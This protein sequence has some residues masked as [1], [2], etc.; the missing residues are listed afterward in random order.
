MKRFTIARDKGRRAKGIRYGKQWVLNI[1][2][3]TVLNEHYAKWIVQ[4]L[5]GERV[6]PPELPDIWKTDVKPTSEDENH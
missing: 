4:V 3:C 5:N 2:T 6:E 1:H